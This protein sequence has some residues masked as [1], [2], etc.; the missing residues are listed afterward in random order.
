MA[1][2]SVP[3]NTFTHT[4]LFQGVHHLDE[5]T[6]VLHH[7]VDAIVGR[8]DLVEDDRRPSRRGRRP[9]NESLL[10]ATRGVHTG[11]GEEIDHPEVAADGTVECWQRRFPQRRA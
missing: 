11:K 10:P 5:V 8:R 1:W 4:T 7:R 3:L 6:L 9:V 2:G